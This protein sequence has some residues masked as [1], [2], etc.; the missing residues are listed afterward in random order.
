M[1]YRNKC[2]PS[3]TWWAK[4]KDI[5]RLLFV[6]LEFSCN[7][8][9]CAHGT[10]KP[11]TGLSW[12]NLQSSAPLTHTLLKSEN[13]TVVF[14]TNLLLVLRCQALLWSQPWL[15]MSYNPALID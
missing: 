11:H 3:A 10:I 6:Y 8:R 14:P 7:K 9:T 13:I 15:S 5:Q 4:I 1:G 2:I 12:E